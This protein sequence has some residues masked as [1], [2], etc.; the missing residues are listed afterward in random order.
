VSLK[1]AKARLGMALCDFGLWV[2]SLGPKHP[3][4]Q[5]AERDLIQLWR[6]FKETAK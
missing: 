4:E 5:Q 1:K 6:N 2:L 3:A